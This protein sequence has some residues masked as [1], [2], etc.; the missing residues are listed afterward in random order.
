MP[1]AS[2][3]HPYGRAKLAFD[4]AMRM[5]AYFF[6]PFTSGR[7]DVRVNS[8]R[9]AGTSAPVEGVEVEAATLLDAAGA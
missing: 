1:N 8:F 7:E 9:D 3:A 4:F 6:S 2:F 5:A